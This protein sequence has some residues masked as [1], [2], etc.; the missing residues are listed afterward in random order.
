GIS[1]VRQ[2]TNESFASKADSAFA[3]IQAA[4]PPNLQG[5]IQQITTYAV[6]TLPPVP[7]TVSF[8]NLRNCIRTRQKISIEY[9]DQAK[10]STTRTIWPLGLVF[11]NPVWLLISWCETRKSFRNFRL[12]RIHSLSMSEAH[13]TDQPDKNLTAY[14]NTLHACQAQ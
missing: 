11:F 6:P 10:N 5:E 14:L 12:D 7:R 2:W 9:C 8:S 13:F 4:L 1:M 3:K